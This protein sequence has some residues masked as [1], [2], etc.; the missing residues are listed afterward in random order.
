MF[1]KS[2]ILYLAL[3]AAALPALACANAVDDGNAGVDAL[4]NGAYDKAVKLFTHALRSGELKGDDEE[5]AYLSRGKAYLGEHDD[6]LAIADFKAALKLKPGDSEA[7]S[8]LDE[9]ESGAAPAPEPPSGTG[10]GFLADLAGRYFWYEVSGQ[11]PHATVIRI[12]WTTPQQVLN[13]WVRTKA[14]GIASGEYKLDPATGKIIEAEA[15]PG[16]VFYGTAIASPTAVTEYF[17]IN[18]K[19]SR[20]VLTRQADGSYVVQAQ[21]YANGTWQNG[22]SVS[23]V[24][25]SEA[26]AEK[27]GFF[28]QKK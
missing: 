15:V 23:F 10:W 6:K 24:E 28:K 21:D 11:D 1:R 25:I 7:Q 9:A 22:E 2:A 18:G 20:N 4:N 12:A 16:V 17:F 8:A 5:F 14:R 19:P 13:Y 26:E 3:A 27:K